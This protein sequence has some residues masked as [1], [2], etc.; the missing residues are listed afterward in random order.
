MDSVKWFDRKFDFGFTEN[1]FPV[2]IDRLKSTPEKL[3]RKIKEI[4]PEHLVLRVNDRWS[5]KEN[6]GHLIDLEP[7]GQRRLDDILQGR[8]EMQAAD[9][10]NEK[11]AQ[12]DHNSRSSPYLLQEFSVLRNQT[13]LLLENLDKND[14]LRSS[15]H[16]RLKIPMRTID[17]F[18]FVA[19]HDDHHFERILY[20]QNQ[21]RR[22]R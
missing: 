12:A 4:P 22:S 9:L 21:L 17:L 10:T 6:I 18:W 15:R 14:L 3:F 5:I 2:L 7:L 8:E 19:E 13:I 1:I 16:P 20:L 11:T